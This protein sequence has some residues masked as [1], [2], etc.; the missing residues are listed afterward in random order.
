MMIE[1]FERTEEEC[2]DLELGY[3]YHELE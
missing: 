2:E 3:P 1:S